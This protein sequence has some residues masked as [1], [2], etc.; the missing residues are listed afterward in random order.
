MQKINYKSLILF[1]FFFLYALIESKGGGDFKLFL[2]ASKD[3]FE[4]KN[5]YTETYNEWY[6]YYYD[7]FFAI[8]IYPLSFLPLYVAKFI[9]ISF[10]IFLVYKTWNLLSS[11]IPIELLSEKSVN[12]LRFLVWFFMLRFLRDNLHLCQ[13]TISVLFLS[14]KGLDLIKEKKIVLGSL[15]ISVGISVKI[16][17][18]VLIPY[19]L[20]RSYFKSSILILVFVVSLQFLPALVLNFNYLIFLLEQRITSLNPAN[21]NHILDTSERSFHSLTT[22]LSTLLIEN[23]GDSHALL[24]KRNFANITLNNLKII[25]QVVR[26][27]LVLFS[28]Y[29]LKNTLFRTQVRKLDS[30]Y[31]LSY[32]FLIVPLIF[33]HQQHYAF[34][35]IFPAIVYLAFY[36]VY[37][38]ENAEKKRGEFKFALLISFGFIVYFLTNCHLILG[39]FNE[40]YDHFKI[41]TY[42]VMLLIPLLVYSSPKKLN[43]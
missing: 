40:Y 22:L 6:H 37:F 17:P 9:W 42:G 24:L 19:L 5:I 32:I 43:L 36:W 23:C 8:I 41:L 15:F 14:L 12:I 2:E 11:W 31:E 4:G 25:I 29:F 27:V 3:L 16:L 33:P 1:L 7:L 38:Y 10:N 35:F 28:I 26:L 30:L 18:I 21:T 13:M 39:A 20:Y 34:Y